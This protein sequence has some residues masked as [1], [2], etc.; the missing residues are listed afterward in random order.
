MKESKIRL[1]GGGEELDKKF[2]MLVYEGDSNQEELLLY[3]QS[4]CLKT[5]MQWKQKWH[6]KDWRTY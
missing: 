4:N 3:F 1:F 6:E 2:E 5:Q